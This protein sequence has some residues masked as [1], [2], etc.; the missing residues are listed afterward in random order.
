M[1]RC[2]G[3]LETPC[4]QV[5]QSSTLLLCFMSSPQISGLRHEKTISLLARR[6]EPQPQTPKGLE[7]TVAGCRSSARRFHPGSKDGVG[8]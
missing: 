3:A 2:R 7:W 5:S 6:Q 4:S 8:G 1:P